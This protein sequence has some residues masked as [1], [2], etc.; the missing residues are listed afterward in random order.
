MVCPICG[1]D[2]YV[3]DCRRRKNES[4]YEIGFRRRR[5]CK[6]CGHRFTTYETYANISLAAKYDQLIRKLNKVNKLSKE[7][8][9]IL[10]EEHY[11]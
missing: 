5:E 10:K 8:D 9:D 11:D 6:Q 7:L 1:N 3:T 4:G 2:T